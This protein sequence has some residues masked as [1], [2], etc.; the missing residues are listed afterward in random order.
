MKMKKNE[1][2]SDAYFLQLSLNRAVNYLLERIV[3]VL[4]YMVIMR[5]WVVRNLN[6]LRS[7]PDLTGGTL[8]ILY[9]DVYSTQLPHLKRVNIR[10]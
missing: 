4:G 7:A 10:N 1:K 6:L 9:F 8:F 5:S 3:G 2:P